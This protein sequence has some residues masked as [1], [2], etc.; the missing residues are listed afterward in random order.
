MEIIIKIT[1][2][3]I[4]KASPIIVHGIGFYYT[5]YLFWRINEDTT[6][7]SNVCF[8]F[9]A[10]MTGLS[11]RMASTLENK[12]KREKYIYCGERFF[13][14]AFLLLSASLIKYTTLSIMDSKIF[15]TYE[16]IGSIIIFPFQLIFILLFYHA[17]E[18]A[19]SGIYICNDIFW[20]GAGN[21]II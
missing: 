8:G 15:V 12:E 14:A 18:S 9:T 7:I 21:K 11:L 1:Q 10:I 5:L 3:F 19:M 13:H 4:S 17:L 16:L 6:S 2:K 20:E